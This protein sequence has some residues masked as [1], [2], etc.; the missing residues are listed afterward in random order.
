MKNPLQRFVRRRSGITG[1]VIGQLRDPKTGQITAQ[2]R[3]KNIVTTAGDEFY[4]QA[5]AQRFGNG[6]A[7][8]AFA[9]MYLG[10]AGNAPAKNSVFSDLTAVVSGSERSFDSGYPQ[11]NDPDSTNPVGDKTR[12][13]TYRV[14][15]PAGTA[16][17]T[18]I[19]RV[20]IS[21]ASAVAGSPLLMYATFSAFDKGAGDEL[22]MFVNHTFTGS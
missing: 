1:L 20:A 13:L 21:I 22:V 9:A 7:A 17:A 11:D 12:V 3:H 15:Y 19:N 5:I 18:G 10:T 2:F 6:T 16:T 4:A 14:T 8:N